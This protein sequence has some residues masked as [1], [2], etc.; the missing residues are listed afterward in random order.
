MRR[1][2]AALALLLAAPAT[3]Q[4]FSYDPP[5]AL[6]DGSGQGRADET[7]YV[8]DMRFPIEEA[9]AFPNSQ[10]YRPGGYRGPGGGQCDPSNY[11]YPWQDNYCESRSWDMPL[12]PAGQGHQ[13][14]DI[15]PATCDDDLWWA[16]A[17]ESG[18]ITSIG[19]YSVSLM[20]DTGTRHRYL[21]LSMD[22]L[23]VREGQRVQRGDR[24]GL[25]SNDFGG[26]ITT[27]HLHYDLLQNVNGVGNVY[28]PT[29]MSLVRSYEALLG[30]P[31]QPC[32]VIAE[33][34]GTIDDGDPCYRLFGPMDSWRQVG[35]AGWDG[36]LRW[37]FA[38]DQRRSNVARWTIHPEVAGRYAVE[39]YVENGYGGSQRAPYL[40]RHGGAEQ[41]VRVD[42][43]AAVG[44]VR[45][46]VFAF[47]AGADQYVEVSD[48]S[49]EPLD[50][51]RRIPADA[52]RVVPFDGDE[53]PPPPPPPVDA[54]GPPPPP[55]PPPVD[56]G[57]P[58]PAR[59]DAAT[60]APPTQQ[61]PEGG[62]DP[63]PQTEAGAYDPFADG[64]AGGAREQS[65]N[66]GGCSTAPG[67]AGLAWLLVLP[68]IALRRR[69]TAPRRSRCR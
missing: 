14:Q 40:I 17:A 65:R 36:D 62:G 53:P 64:G 60:G 5:G 35:D 8:P 59:F 31:A 16:V 23:M 32:G 18:T 24:I 26:E 55:P 68:V 10:V 44:W 41:E 52:L 57:A 19:S 1:P 42:L 30:Q 56:A 48:F 27:I 46:G 50:A 66:S 4:E 49:G 43:S 7:V 15:R 13:G 29:Y 9:P 11:D 3:A 33:T 67:P 6:V 2:L 61:P 39:V 69:A 47:A 58:P 21:H 28:V 54:G 25:V 63:V 20:S 45:I 51:Q 37:T 34:G 12:C 22:R 38:W